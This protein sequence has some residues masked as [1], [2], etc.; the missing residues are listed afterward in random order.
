MGPERGEEFRAAVQPAEPR[1]S[2]GL[3]K[4]D[5]AILGKLDL[6][7][8]GHEGITERPVRYQPLLHYW[9]LLGVA[10]AHRTPVAQPVF[11]DRRYNC[12]SSRKLGA[13][14]GESVSHHP[15]A[16]GQHLSCSAE[17]AVKGG[18]RASSL[19]GQG[20]RFQLPD[21]SHT[22]RPEVLF[23]SGSPSLPP[24][25]YRSSSRIL[26]QRHLRRPRAWPPPSPSSHQI[27]LENLLLSDRSSART[28]CPSQGL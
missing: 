28:A 14:Q 25:N 27:Q 16:F 15:R 19:Q 10:G 3:S 7:G 8:I 23:H 4:T 24:H 12:G 26:P 11:W 5:K 17:G 2:V 6:T 21:Q 1:A 22:E 20:T 18:D 9:G 13:G